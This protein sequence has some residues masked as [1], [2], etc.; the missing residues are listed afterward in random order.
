M[1]FYEYVVFFDEPSKKEVLE[2]VD[3]ETQWNLFSSEENLIGY[4]AREIAE[5]KA[6]DWELYDEDDYVY[7]VIRQEQSEEWE[8]TKV[9]VQYIRMFDDEQIDLDDLD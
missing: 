9:C 4:V 8:I 3:D 1:K 6:S 5:S 7:L 2:V